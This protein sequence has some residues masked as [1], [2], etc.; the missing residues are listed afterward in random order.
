MSLRV[1]VIGAGDA[2]GSG[3]R[4]NT[5]FLVDRGE[6][7]FLIDC[8]ASAIIGLRRYGVDPNTIG[9]IVLSHLHGDH[10]GGLPFFIL[11]AQLVSRRTRPLVIA[12]PHGLPARL[13]ALMEAMFPGSS[14][15]V[16]KFSTELIE[17]A[18]ETPATLGPPGLLA[19]GYPVEHPSGSPSLALRLECD[20]RVIAY[21]GDTQWVDALIEAGRHADLLIAEAYWFD[22]KLPF[23]LD[24]KTLRGRLA[25]IGAKRLLLT[26]MSAEMLGRLSEVDRGEPASDGL[27]IQID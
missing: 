26:H 9:T 24:F 5:C 1:K 10:F 8:G 11:D 7:S 4:L 16:R 15:A 23:H 21:T 18:A 3:G 17:F 13:D 27:E 12:G 2:F 25:E 14:K 20:G 22:R 6:Q 19:T